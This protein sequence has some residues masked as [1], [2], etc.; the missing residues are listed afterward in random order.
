MNGFSKM[1]REQHPNT[2]K[3][4]VYHWDM[5]S[6]TL[7]IRKGGNCT[8]AQRANMKE[9]MDIGKIALTAIDGRCYRV[10]VY[11]PHSFMVLKPNSVTA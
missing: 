11:V 6:Q 1:S 7:Y 9:A 10:N 5:A 2:E 4:A 3:S 8:F